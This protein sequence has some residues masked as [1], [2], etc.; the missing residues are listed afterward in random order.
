MQEVFYK[1][2]ESFFGTSSIANHTPISHTSS[3]NLKLWFG[4]IIFIFFL[5]FYLF[6]GLNLIT[7]DRVKSEGQ[8]ENDM[9]FQADSRYAVSA[10]TE[11]EVHHHRILLHP[12]FIIYFNPLGYIINQIV[13]DKDITATIYC[14]IVG[15]LGV[16]AALYFFLNIGIGS[17]RSVLYA[18]ILGFSSS[19]L[20]FS[21][22]PDSYI[23]SALGIILLLLIAEKSKDIKSWI[24]VSVYLLGITISN[25]A[26]AVSAAFFYLF[27]GNLRLVSYRKKL[28]QYM[29]G[30]SVAFFLL[31]VLQKIIY[32]RWMFQYV[33]RAEKEQQFFVHFENMADALV[34]G[35]QLFMHLFYYNIVAPRPSLIQHPLF[36]SIDLISFQND[37]LFSYALP[38]IVACL[39]WTAIIGIALWSF[40]KNRLYHHNLIKTALVCLAINI[41]IH[42]LYGE[43]L[44]LYSSHWTFFVIVLIFFSLEKTNLRKQYTLPYYLVL[45]IFSLFLMVNNS[46]EAAAIIKAF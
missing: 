9:Y 44:M 33:G 39:I 45:V 29:G 26:F 41:G 10:L 7:A 8:H 27:K 20:I 19:Q 15:A 2:R 17:L 35:K 16:C 34:R 4:M 18:S 36:P 24:A 25:I 3:S 40:I 28:L 1:K 14:A 43:D 5:S 32:Q 12:L 21:I 13:H 38:G 31:S 42:F 22:V 30:I 46:M 23:F 37:T 11:P 6:H